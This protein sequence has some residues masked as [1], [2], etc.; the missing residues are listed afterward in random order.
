MAD[1]VWIAQHDAEEGELVKVVGMN[2]N[3]SV[4]YMNYV[5]MAAAAIA[6]S[7]KLVVIEPGLVA[8]SEAQ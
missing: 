7:D 2:P 6:A 3:G 4:N 8:P 1:T 5:S